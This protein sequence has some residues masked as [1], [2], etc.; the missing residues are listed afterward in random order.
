VREHLGGPLVG[1]HHADHAV[2]AGRIQL[3]AALEQRHELLEQATQLG[4]AFTTQRDLV[5]PD[6]HDGL[7][8]RLLD[9]AQV[10]VA[11]AE[12]RSHQVRARDDDG[13]GR[14]GRGHASLRR[15]AA[16]IC[17]TVAPPR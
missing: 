12:Q 17:S 10:L 3:V 16:S 1:T 8:E 2:E 14:V 7:G 5:A 9:L 15:P 13:D 11:R 4:R 6:A